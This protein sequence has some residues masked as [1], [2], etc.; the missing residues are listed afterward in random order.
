MK[1]KSVRAG[2]YYAAA[3]CFCVAAVI[4]FLITGDS[5]MGVVW[6]CLGS[7]MLA[8]GSSA[9]KGDAAREEGEKEAEGEIPICR[10]MEG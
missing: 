9:K 6:L 10:D 7:V 3:L 4:S 1:K 5:G 8:L 2:L